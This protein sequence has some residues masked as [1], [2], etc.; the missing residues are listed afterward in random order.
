[1]AEDIFVPK[2]PG[3]VVDTVD[4]LQ[5]SFGDLN[6]GEGKISS[7]AMETFLRAVLGLTAAGVSLT[8]I[9]GLLDF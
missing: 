6:D 9:I 7:D 3:E 4:E 5:A 8:A 2:K 1:M